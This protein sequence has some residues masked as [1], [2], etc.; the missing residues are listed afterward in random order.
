MSLVPSVICLGEALVD[1]L[2][3]LGVDL[4]SESTYQCVDRLGG[5]PANAACALARL[6]TA[7]GFA[8][9]L[10]KDAIGNAFSNLFAERGLFT[11]F[12]QFDPVRPTRIVLVSRSDDGD[13]MFRGFVGD[14]GF[15]FADQF[16]Q[17]FILPPAE[18]LLVGTVPLS[19]PTSAAVLMSVVQQSRNQGTAIAIDVNWRPTF[20]D[21]SA[22]PY[23]GPSVASKAAIQPLLIQASLIKFSREEA[24]WFFNT[25][26]PH[27]I[28]QALPLRPDVVVTDGS[29]LVRW[30]FADSSGQYFPI[31]P[32]T[33][34]DT[35]GAGDA[36][37][38]G[39]LHFW[40]APPPERIRFASA[41]GALVCTGV[42]GIEPQP[43]QSQVEAFLGGVS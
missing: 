43:T 26:D 17:P 6:G 13:R 1:R 31:K 14:S 15:G 38:A 16:L 3:P 37:T 36:F 23:S 4:S 25:D 20:W 24:V 10:G 8:G 28:Q 5:A 35:T 9:R 12:L 22:S 32:S 18:W 33:I 29:G 30:K 19:V 40:S 21:P 42:G 34:V 41:C 2:G 27:T 11:E 39:L 7:V